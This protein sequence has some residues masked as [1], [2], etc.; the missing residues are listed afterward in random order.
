M[1]ECRF[2]KTF[3]EVCGAIL[4]KSPKSDGRKFFIRA[5]YSPRIDGEPYAASIVG[6]L[7]RLG[8]L[9][10]VGFLSLPM[11]AAASFYGVTKK[12]KIRRPKKFYLVK[13]E[14]TLRRWRRKPPV[15][16]LDSFFFFKKH[17]TSFYV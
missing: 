15:T 16:S 14:E 12:F 5:L 11:S 8:I 3:K 7:W 6:G 10:E 9:E 17:Q 2:F 4:K 13:S 1:P